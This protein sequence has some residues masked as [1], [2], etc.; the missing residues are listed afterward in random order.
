MTFE[1]PAM[2][3]ALPL[4]RLITRP[5][6]VH[7]LD[8]MRSVSPLREPVAS[9]SM[10]GVPAKPG[11]VVPSMITASLIWSRNV[12][13]SAIV[14]GP[15]PIAK[16]IVS[17]PGFRSALA[18]ACP[19]DPGPLGA[20]VVTVNVAAETETHHSDKM[21]VKRRRTI[22][23]G[24]TI[25]RLV[26][27]CDD[28]SCDR[29]R[30]GRQDHFPIHPHQREDESVDGDRLEER[31][32]DDVVQAT[33]RT[34]LAKSRPR[35]KRGHECQRA[36]RVQDDREFVVQRSLER[37]LRVSLSDRKS[38]QTVDEDRRKER[39]P[40][41]ALDFHGGFHFT[42]EFISRAGRRGGSEESMA[43]QTSSRF[44]RRSNLK[45]RRC[46]A[47]VRRRAR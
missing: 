9:I 31:P 1:S 18:I 26:R 43:A 32:G 2:V 7:P 27:E 11:C 40:D 37:S 4:V 10:I 35:E 17:R 20:L 28:E 38:D 23:P 24:A 19:S 39:R 29:Q 34:A 22:G 41:D 30:R 8:V 6:I 5:L 33:R 44:A 25:S 12:P 14:C 16:T 45:T 13:A 42:T 15:E 3:M 46:P 47:L 21:A 36:D